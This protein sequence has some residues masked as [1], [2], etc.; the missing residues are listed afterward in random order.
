M[1]KKDLAYYLASLG[2]IMDFHEDLGTT[3]NTL[4]A[5]EY[6]RAHRE[7]LEVIQRELKDG[8]RQRHSESVRERHP[9]PA[10]RESELRGRYAWQ[11]HPVQSAPRPH[12]NHGH[13][14]AGATRVERGEPESS[15]R[16]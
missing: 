14:R 12:E 9:A 2:T 11:D 1:D 4:L 6:A 10:S 16:E 8:E 15:D 3:K 7:L 5:D 13:E